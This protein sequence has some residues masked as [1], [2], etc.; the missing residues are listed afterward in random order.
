GLANAL[1]V[2][3]KREAAEAFASYLELQPQDRESRRQLARLWFEQADYE[4]AIAE[5]DRADKGATPPP[6]SLRLRADV[7]IAR[8]N[9]DAAIGVLQA[10]LQQ[11]TRDATLHAD[12]GHTYM[13]KLDFLAHEK[14]LCVVLGLVVP[15]TAVLAER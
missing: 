10:A 9:W 8:Q 11:P 1:F 4:K 12:L 5:L 6:D 7:F 3:N 2:Q 14:E 15:L 13:H